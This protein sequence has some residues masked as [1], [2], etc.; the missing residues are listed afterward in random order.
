M[1]YSPSSTETTLSTSD[2]YILLVNSRGPG[3][4]DFSVS[5]VCSAGPTGRR[6]GVEVGPTET[7]VAIW[8]DGWFYCL[9]S[10]STSIPPNV[11]SK[12]RTSA[13]KPEGRSAFLA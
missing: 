2:L 7:A 8:L 10:L 13:L 3:P 1:F 4:S 9:P 5:S 12:F 11:E 6:S